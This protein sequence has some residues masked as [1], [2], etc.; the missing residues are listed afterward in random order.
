DFASVDV[1]ADPFDRSASSHVPG[2]EQRRVALVR[3]NPA[4]TV[5]A[6]DVMT[7]D[8]ADQPFFV[9]AA[10]D[11]PLRDLPIAEDGYAIAK[12]EHLVEPMRDIEDRDAAR[13][14]VAYD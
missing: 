4:T 10:A 5:R 2:G 11:R 1:E 8:R 7:D 13:R 6:L 9:Q 12:I 14:E 3:R